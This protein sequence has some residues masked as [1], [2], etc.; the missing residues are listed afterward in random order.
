MLTTSLSTAPSIHSRAARRATSPSINTDKSLKAVRPPPESTNQRPAVLGLYQ[1]A[2]VSK[3]TKRGRKT[4]MSSRARKRHDSALER[5]EAI[6]D[7]TALKVAKSK[8][9]A[10]NIEVRKKNWDE[11]NGAVGTVKG[12]KLANNMFGALGGEDNDDDEEVEEVEEFDEDMEVVEEPVPV[13]GSEK[14]KST[15]VPA[16]TPPVQDDDEEIL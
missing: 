13:K 11:I 5:A 16:P 6:V 8:R 7:R 10:S 4:V 2:G 9:S 1:N 3:K 14:A 15:A 12:A